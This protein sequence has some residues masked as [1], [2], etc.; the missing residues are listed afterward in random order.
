MFTDRKI[1]LG[2]GS[3]REQFTRHLTDELKKSSPEKT[4]SFL[5]ETLKKRLEKKALF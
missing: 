5:R 1:G 3:L 2:N 4:E